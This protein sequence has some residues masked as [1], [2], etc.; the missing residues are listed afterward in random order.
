MK[1]IGIYELNH[2]IIFSI[3]ILYTGYYKDNTLHSESFFLKLGYDKL[4]SKAENN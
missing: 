1:Y 2:M 4:K 3:I